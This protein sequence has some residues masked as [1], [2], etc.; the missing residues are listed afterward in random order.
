[1]P[2][3]FATPGRKP[4]MTICAFFTSGS[5]TSREGEDFRSRA[6]LLLLRFSVLNCTGTYDRPGSPRGGSTLITSA[7]RSAKIAVANGPGTNIEKS[8]TRTPRSGSQG[9]AAMLFEVRRR[10]DDQALDLADEH[11]HLLR[12]HGLGPDETEIPRAGVIGREIRL[13]VLLTR[14]VAAHGGGS[15]QLCSAMPPSTTMEAPVT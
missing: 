6:K 4:S 1:M 7:P 15:I 9:S 12:A 11:F 10:V 13:Y 5:T 14:E 8:T 2:R 3:R